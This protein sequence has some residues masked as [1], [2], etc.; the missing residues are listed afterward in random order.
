MRSP[1]HIRPVHFQYK[2]LLLIFPLILLIVWLYFTPPGLLGKLDAIAY[3]ICHRIATHSFSLD[4]QQLPLCARCTGMYMGALACLIVQFFQGRQGKLPPLPVF[5]IMGLFTI[6]FGIDGANSYITF[7][8][9]LH[10]LY[11]PQNWLRLVTGFGMGLSMSA[12][13]F[14]IFNQSIWKNWIDRS[15]FSSVKQCFLV[16]CVSILAILTVISGKPYLLY[17]VAI[18]SISGVLALLTMI[19]SIVLVMLFRK[20]NQYEHFN[21]LWLLLIM[22]FTLAM[23]QI[24]IVDLGRF[25]LTH[26]WAGF[27]L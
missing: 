13:L 21:Q 14:P 22:G 8:P 19:Y 18:L 23:I 17:P 15:P 27:S 7:I 12:I 4:G 25:A 11:Q 26:T 20:D 9:G 10:A 3:G 16:L 6:A 2:W 1:F 24:S 5:I